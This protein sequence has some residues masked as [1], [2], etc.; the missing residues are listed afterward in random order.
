MRV[1]PNIVSLKMGM[2]EF[3]PTLNFACTI[4]GYPFAASLLVPLGYSAEYSQLVTVPYRAF[5][6]FLSLLCV[7]IGVFGARGYPKLTRIMYIFLF[8]FLLGILRVSVD[9]FAT[10]G[11]EE[12]S[13]VFGFLASSFFSAVSVFMSYRYI[14]FDASV[15]F[16]LLMCAF[17]LSL[18]PLGV[19]FSTADLIIDIQGLRAEGS[20][21]LYSIAYGFVGV[22]AAILV[23][24]VVLSGSFSFVFKAFALVLIPLALHA[25]FSSGS[26]SPLFSLAIAFVVYFSTASRNYI[27]IFVISFSLMLLVYILRDSI[28]SALSSVAP[29]LAS[30]TEAM[31]LDGFLSGRDLLAMDGLKEA[32]SHPIFGSSTLNQKTGVTPIIGY[33][34]AIID[35]LAY[36]GFFGGTLVIVF[37]AAVGYQAFVVLRN[38]I[39]F[40]NY[41]I[42]FLFC[43]YYVFALSSSGLFHVNPTLASLIAAVIAMS[44]EASSHPN[45]EVEAN[46]TSIYPEG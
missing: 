5:A 41:Y 22:V 36:Y 1:F 3:I 23:C 26:R 6:L 2:S 15:A 7:L 44:S 17:V 12:T 25:I 42:A 29:L 4:A 27:V 21:A 40:R 9:L 45:L 11:Y 30:R 39:F 28:L 10:P 46:S 14:R 37:L 33:H 16:I 18:R 20:A 19:G 13:R 43:A 34:S 38:R 8:C 24:Y 35:A 31:I 32:I